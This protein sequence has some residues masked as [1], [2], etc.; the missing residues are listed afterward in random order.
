MTQHRAI[1]LPDEMVGQRVVLRPYREEDADALW[2][3]VEESRAHLAPWMPWVGEY[4]SSADARSFAREARARWL[5]RD[6]L[7]V[8]IF[9]KDSGRLVGGSGLHRI[10]WVVRSFEIGYWVRVSVEGRGF[11]TETVLLLTRL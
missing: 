10:D 5:L 9:E 11:V 2:D 8:G 6:D 1:E 7:A 4:R 3:A